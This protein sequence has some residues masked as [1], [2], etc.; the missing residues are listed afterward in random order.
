MNPQNGSGPGAAST[1]AT[2]RSTPVEGT[3]S[4]GHPKPAGPRQMPGLHGTDRGPGTAAREDG[5]VLR[6]TE[7]LPPSRPAVSGAA[8]SGTLA[9][10]SIMTSPPER[11]PARTTPNAAGRGV[12]TDAVTEWA[13]ASRDREREAFRALYD[14]LYPPPAIRRQEATA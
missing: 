14:A 12:A 9:A 2:G 1:Q 6:R 4:D 3:A 5:S 7:G 13:L 10:G 8:G 11:T